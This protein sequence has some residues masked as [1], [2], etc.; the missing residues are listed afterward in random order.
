MLIAQAQSEHLPLL[1]RDRAI[2]AYGN[3]AT[4]LG[5]PHPVP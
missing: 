4:M 1:T 5:Y 2:A 3:E